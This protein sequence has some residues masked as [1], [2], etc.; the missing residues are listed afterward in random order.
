LSNFSK[1]FY[2]WLAVS[3]NEAQRLSYGLLRNDTW[4]Y[5]GVDR[6][7]VKVQGISDWKF[8]RNEL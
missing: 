8:H 7:I 6:K 4:C 1:E 3:D 5:S 2:H